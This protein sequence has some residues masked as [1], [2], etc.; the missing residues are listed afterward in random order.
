[1]YSEEP[2][3]KDK[4]AEFLKW[5]QPGDKVTP[6]QIEEIKTHVFLFHS[7]DR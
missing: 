3:F 1:M 6:E 4:L 5:I 2:L 7:F